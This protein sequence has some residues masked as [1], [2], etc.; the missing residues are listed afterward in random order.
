M[1]IITECCVCRDYKNKETH[2]WYTP[3][4]A[5]RR[6]NHYHLH[7]RLSHA[8]CPPCFILDLRSNGITESQI[9]KMIK[10][11]K[12]IIAPDNTLK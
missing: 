3:T 9:E 5:E 6:D 1:T 7:K 2:K 8:F 10:D 12:K 11:S 4:P